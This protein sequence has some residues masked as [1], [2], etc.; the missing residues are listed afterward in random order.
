MIIYE[1][2][3]NAQHICVIINN[4][5]HT[6]FND[7]TL[8]A[9]T[10]PASEHGCNRIVYMYVC[11]SFS[12]Y[13]RTAAEELRVHSCTCTHTFMYCNISFFLFLILSTGKL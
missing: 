12:L 3:S 5:R 6:Q 9:I 8:T 13:R 11:S 4:N 2:Y 7:S 1:L 10:L